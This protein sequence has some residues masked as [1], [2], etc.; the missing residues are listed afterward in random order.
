H[1][2]GPQ[3]RRR[4][5][6]RRR[7]EQTCRRAEQT[8]RRAEQTRRRLGREVTGA[9]H[10]PRRDPGLLTLAS[11]ALPRLLAFTRSFPA[12]RRWA[13]GLVAARLISRLASAAP[14]KARRA[15]AHLA[16]EVSASKRPLDGVEIVL[17][18]RFP[19]R[20]G[21]RFVAHHSPPFLQFTSS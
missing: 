18:V 16:A 3:N 11:A 15:A 17:D 21:F 1:R 7:A 12:R 14:G 8:R 2:A 5:Q 10:Q 4:T 19:L 6:T 13:L 9:G 20:G